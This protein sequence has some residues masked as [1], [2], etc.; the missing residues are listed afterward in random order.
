VSAP[1]PC[2]DLWN[3]SLQQGVRFAVI[4]Q[5]VLGT[6]GLD[7]TLNEF[8]LVFEMA[9]SATMRVCPPMLASPPNAPRTQQEQGLEQGKVGEVGMWGNGTW[10]R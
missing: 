5:L 10:H 2:H 1:Q 7:I 6:Q 4:E 9:G 3:P 8:R